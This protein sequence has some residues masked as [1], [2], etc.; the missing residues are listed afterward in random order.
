MHALGICEGYVGNGWN[1]TIIGGDCLSDYAL[2]MPSLV[3]VVQVKEPVGVFKY[4]VWWYRIFKA[5]KGELGQ[6]KFN[7]VMIRYVVSSFFLIRLISITSPKSLKKILEVNSFLYHMIASYPLWLNHFVAFFEIKLANS[8]D[9]LYVVSKAMAKDSRNVRCTADVV[10]V[11]N[12]ATKKAIAFKREVSHEDKSPRLIYLGTLMPYWDFEYFVQAI[13]NLHKYINLEVV[14]FGDGPM[15]PYLKAKLA[16]SA[17]ITFLGRFSRN[18]LGDILFPSSDILL[19]PPKTEADMVLTGGLSTKLFDYLS[20]GIPILAPSDGEINSILADKVNSVLYRR[21]DIDSLRCSAIELLE[22]RGLRDQVAQ[23]AYSD[24]IEK[25]S[26]DARM[27]VIIE[28][29]GCED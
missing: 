5:C 23:A 24:F 12:G 17:N 25:Y 15:L 6:G 3:N 18:D 28:R 21:D 27:K 13:N 2:D 10:C 14:I 22:S 11:E 19:L 29:S 9:V 7:S 26:W 4:P 8:F 1:V 16:N 20:M